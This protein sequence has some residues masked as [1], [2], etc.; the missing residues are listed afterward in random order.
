MRRNRQLGLRG[1]WNPHHI[2]PVQFGGLNTL[3]NCVALCVNPPNCHLTVGHAGW[4]G[5]GALPNRGR[6]LEVFPYFYGG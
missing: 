3:E 4:T 6:L 1:A 5:Q 2:L